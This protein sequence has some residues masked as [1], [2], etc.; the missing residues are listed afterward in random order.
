MG[1]KNKPASP[2]EPPYKALDIAAHMIQ[3]ATGKKDP[4]S[5]KKLQKLLYYAQVWY[6][7]FFDKKLFS[8]DM[9]AWVHGP[10]VAKVYGHYKN[11]D[12]QPIEPETGVQLTQL[13]Q[14]VELFLLNVW[15]VYGKYD[16]DYLEQLSHSETPWR[17]ARR[18]L[19]SH[20][21]SKAKINLVT[22]KSFYEKK[23]TP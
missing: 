23:I 21:A 17:E 4:I 10:V 5:N 19:E 1:T 8:E 11:Y 6:Y 16:A 20:V 3:L 2:K 12:F 13:S 18:G 22:A 7:T 9:E 14:E 15:D